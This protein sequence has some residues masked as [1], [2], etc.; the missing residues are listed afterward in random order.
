MLTDRRHPLRFTVWTLVAIWVTA[1]FAAG[2][3]Y[4]VASVFEADEGAYHGQ[5][6]TRSGQCTRAPTF[7]SLVRIGGFRPV[8]AREA[9]FVTKTES[10]QTPVLIYMWKG[11]HSCATEWAIDDH[12]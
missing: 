12:S 7:T 10:L 2:A 9:A 5:D 6:Y 3:T 1:T 4:L 11:E 8:P